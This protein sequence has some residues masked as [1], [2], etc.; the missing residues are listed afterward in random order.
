MPLVLERP[1]SVE[2][3]SAEFAGLDEVEQKRFAQSFALRPLYKLV[4]FASL[5]LMGLVLV[6][7]GG[8]WLLSGRRW[9]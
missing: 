5:A 4:G 7:A 3:A 9:R 2:V 6:S 8:A 1:V